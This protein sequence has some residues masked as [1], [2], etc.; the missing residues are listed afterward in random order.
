MLNPRFNLFNAN[1]SINRFHNTARCS[2]SVL[3]PFLCFLFIFLLCLLGSS[4]TLTRL[5][6]FIQSPNCPTLKSM[7]SYCTSPPWFY[8]STFFP[9][10]LLTPVLSDTSST[11]RSSVCAKVTTLEFTDA[12]CG[13]AWWLLFY[14][15][16]TE[17]F[18]FWP[19]KLGPARGTRHWPS[20]VKFSAQFQWKLHFDGHLSTSNTRYYFFAWK[21]LSKY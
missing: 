21:T 11:P 7:S 2:C 13:S 9:E 10:V 20:W 19:F 16:G 14:C 17:S 12:Q 15:S 18:H 6:L 1:S 5:C 3:S 4:P 8:Q